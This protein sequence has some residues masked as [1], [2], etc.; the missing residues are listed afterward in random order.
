MSVSCK[1]RISPI[2]ILFFGS[3]LIT[4]LKLRYTNISNFRLWMINCSNLY[5]RTCHVLFR[6]IL[7]YDII[8]IDTNFLMSSL[9]T[10]QSLFPV[11]MILSTRSSGIF[12]QSRKLGTRKRMMNRFEFNSVRFRTVPSLLTFSLSIRRLLMRQ[13]MTSTE[14]QH[15]STP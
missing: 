14:F 3:I 5:Q 8:G 12:W 6:I 10:S 11:Q 7:N 15:L 2:F 13:M 4:F 1:Q 9:R